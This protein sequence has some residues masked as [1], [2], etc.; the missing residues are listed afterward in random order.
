MEPIKV[1]VSH[2]P[3]ELIVWGQENEGKIHAAALDGVHEMIKNKDI[4]ELVLFEFYKNKLDVLPFAEI[5][6]HQSEM[7]DS[8]NVALKWFVENEY[9]EEAARVKNY[10]DLLEY[11]SI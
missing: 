8:L 11:K 9:Y 7:L 6:L 2:D 10:L 4:E 1:I 3:E 5:L